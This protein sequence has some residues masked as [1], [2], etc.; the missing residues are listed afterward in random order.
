M[1]FPSCLLP[2][3]AINLLSNDAMHKMDVGVYGGGKGWRFFW[4]HTK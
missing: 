4:Q 2:L 1:N 3:Q